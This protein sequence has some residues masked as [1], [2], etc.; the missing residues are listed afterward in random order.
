MKRLITTLAILLVVIVAGMTALVLLV[1]PN[2]FR[3]YMAQ[4]VAK[5]SGYQLKLSGELRWHVWP[6]LSIL[7][8]QLSLTAPGASQ[9]AVTAENMRLDV[10]LLPLLS[11]QLKVS[12][13]LLKNAVIRD[14]PSTAGERQPGSPVGPAEGPTGE[15]AVGRGWS[16]DIAR[17]D[18]VDSLFVWQDA[19]G[20]QMNFRDLNLSVR[21][22]KNK[23]G[24]FD[25]SS[26]VS[27]NQQNLQLTVSGNLDASQYP[28]QLGLQVT[29]SGYQISG[30]DLP[31]NG[32]NGHA[33]FN[34]IWRPSG[35][36]FAVSGLSLQANNSDFSG[37]I[38]GQLQPVP[39][40]RARL[41]SDTA[42]FDQL[43]ASAGSSVSQSSPHVVR[44]PV[45]ADTASQPLQQTWLRTANM[46]ISIRASNA[47]WRGLPLA[48]LQLD[49][50]ANQGLINI[51]TLTGQSGAGNFSLPGQID[52]RP[53]EMQV[54]FSPVLR[55][56]ELQPVLA[57]LQLPQAVKG[58]LTLNG[59][60][61]GNGLSNNDILNQWQGEA[62]LGIDQLDT[63]P[64]N[65]PQMVSDAVTRSS[66]RVQA[67]SLA[68][69]PVP[70]LNGRIS[71]TPGVLKITQLRG[72]SHDMQLN[73]QGNISFSARSMDITFALLMKNWQGDSRLVQLLADQP[74]PLRFYG[75]WDKLRY[76][77]PIGQLLNGDM[78]NELRNRLNRWTDHTDRTAPQK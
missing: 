76:A 21:Q 63:A 50:T 60:F 18:I 54:S 65:L 47:I 57:F 14:L 43:L 67:G 13:V 11:H 38:D 31:A 19:S 12:Q 68:H 75:P 36:Q 29:A 34:A 35:Q 56:I 25:F 69:S 78:R 27:R 20:N 62:S 40:L 42:D 55:N 32:I 46:D 61:R 53:A 37:N 9:P 22:Q 73:G 3:G 44:A 7:S 39:R 77:L 2:D 49:T 64:F 59:Q 23:Q 71:L 72:E 66:D 28:Q 58:T 48:H 51:N 33:V 17:L 16:F 10:E 70:E 15:P 30:V 6:K 45:I 24:Q 52:L 4:Q 41:V 1:N 74:I 26:R 8:D 5:R